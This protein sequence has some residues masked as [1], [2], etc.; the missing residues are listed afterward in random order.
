MVLINDINASWRELCV[1]GSI[2]HAARRRPSIFL[3]RDNVRMREPRRCVIRSALFPCKD[4]HRYGV[5]N[6]P[7]KSSI[8]S[9]VVRDTRFLVSPVVSRLSATNRHGGQLVDLRESKF[10][11]WG[12]VRLG[13]ILGYNSAYGGTSIY[14]R[15]TT[16]RSKA[17]S[18][19]CD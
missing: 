9:S 8:L 11:L 17:G 13:Y 2:I 7:N 5:R 4:A 1:V 15:D 12:Q 16:T 6:F 19:K 3:P 14:R 18:D 10:G